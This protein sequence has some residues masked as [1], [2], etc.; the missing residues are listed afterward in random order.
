LL[1]SHLD[2]LRFPS[3]LPRKPLLSLPRTSQEGLGRPRKCCFHCRILRK[4]LRKSSEKLGLSAAFRPAAASSLRRATS[5]AEGGYPQPAEGAQPR[6]TSE[7][8]RGGYPQPE[9]DPAAGRALPGPPSAGAELSRSLP[10]AGAGARP[11][12]PGWA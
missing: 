9:G 8:R 12:F 10:G 11:G 7:L 6:A 2:L 3:C 5:C 4:I 1:R